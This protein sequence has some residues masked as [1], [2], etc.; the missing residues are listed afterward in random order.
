MYMALAAGLANLLWAV[1]Q[2][3]EERKT[4]EKWPFSGVCPQIFMKYASG[5]SGDNRARRH[6]LRY[7]RAHADI[8]TSFIIFI[9]LCVV[10]LG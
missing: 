4:L 8:A 2:A 9:L 7:N 10:L 1:W 5:D 3:G 6:V